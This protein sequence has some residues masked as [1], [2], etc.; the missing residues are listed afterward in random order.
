MMKDD[1]QLNEDGND[2]IQLN[3][4]VNDVMMKYPAER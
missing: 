2:D 3:D 1:I 4:D